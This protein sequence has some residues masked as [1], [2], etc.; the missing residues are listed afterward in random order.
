MAVNTEV[1]ISAIQSKP[2]I[3]QSKHLHHSNRTITRKLWNEI[4]EQFPGSEGKFNNIIYFL[5]TMFDIVP[6]NS[7]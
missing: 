3:W 1:F 6:R 4:K 2:A 5:I 7:L